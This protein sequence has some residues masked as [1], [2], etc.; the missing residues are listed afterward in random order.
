MGI[1]LQKL[2]F[3]V[4][5]SRA[6]NHQRRQIDSHAASGSNRGQQ[7]AFAAP[8]LEHSHPWRDE[9]PVDFD[10]ALA[11]VGANLRRT[12]QGYC[13]V[14]PKFAALARKFRGVQSGSMTRRTMASVQLANPGFGC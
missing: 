8:Q 9:E 1:A 11:I 6:F 12:V 4:P 13:Y 5:A 10:E 7:V 14:I 2:A 3:R